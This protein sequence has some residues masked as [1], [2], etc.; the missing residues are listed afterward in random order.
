MRSVSGSWK[1]GDNDIVTFY[2]NMIKRGENIILFQ[3]SQI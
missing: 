2:F 3:F 1:I